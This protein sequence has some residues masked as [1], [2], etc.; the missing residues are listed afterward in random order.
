MLFA[1]IVLLLAITI[2]TAIIISSIQDTPL[3]HLEHCI[4]LGS[5][6][7]LPVKLH[8]IFTT[9]YFHIVLCVY[10]T[11]SLQLASLCKG[12]NSQEAT[13]IFD[14]WEIFV[15]IKP[16]EMGFSEYGTLTGCAWAR[17]L[18]LSAGQWCPSA[19]PPCFQQQC[20]RVHFFFIRLQNSLYFIN[21]RGTVPNWPHI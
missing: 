19:W 15:E 18:V 3:A 2:L 6:V 7:A 1:C 5:L 13:T 16:A 14:H 20:S 9:K 4:V 17:V 10:F 12:H 11:F 21:W 8:S